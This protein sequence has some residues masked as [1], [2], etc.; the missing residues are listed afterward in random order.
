MVMIKLAGDGRNLQI[1]ELAGLHRRAPLL[2]MALMMALF[3][4]AGI[5]PT[6]GFSGKLLIFKAAIDKG[7]LLLVII[8]MINVVISLY[9]YLLV[10]K[11]AYLDE[12]ATG[13]A[14]LVLSF[15]TRA[16]A[17]A[18]IIFIVVV[19]FYPTALIDLVS[20]AANG[21]P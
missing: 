19:G 21:L 14:P 16:L 2:A 12:P 9:Y 4:L 1:E 13:A 3:G 17:M 8:A 10:L 11:A 6:I 20:T 18:M 15:A 5:P 7:Y